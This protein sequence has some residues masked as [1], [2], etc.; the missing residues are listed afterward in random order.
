MNGNSKLVT[1]FMMMWEILTMNYLILKQKKKILFKRFQMKLKDIGSN[2][3]LIKSFN[4]NQKKERIINHRQKQYSMS[5]NRMLFQNKSGTINSIREQ[6]IRIITN[7]KLS[8]KAI[9]PKYHM[10]YFINRMEQKV[11]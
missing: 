6:N 8:E 2:L 7:K 11:F 5:T 4:S 3:N 9:D 10:N 1:I